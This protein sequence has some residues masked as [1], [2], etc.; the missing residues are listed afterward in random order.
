[1]QEFK[2]KAGSIKQPLKSIREFFF[3]NAA[4]LAGD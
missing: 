4:A 1:M 2:E 3:P